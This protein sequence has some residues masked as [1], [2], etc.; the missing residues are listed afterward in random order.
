ML[1]SNLLL[2]RYHKWDKDKKSC[3]GFSKSACWQHRR[4][5]EQ[6][7]KRQPHKRKCS[8]NRIWD[9]A[10]LRQG[11]P[12]DIVTSPRPEETRIYAPAHSRRYTT[13]CATLNNYAL[14]LFGVMR[15][16][17]PKTFTVTVNNR[18]TVKTK[19]TVKDGIV[20]C[21]YAWCNPLTVFRSNANS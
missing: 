5:E 15:M 14:S 9:R 20:F 21:F 1:L 8:C 4:P 2:C 10:H 11:S 17:V 7:P 18:K 6:T 16:G 19:A 3:P 13:Q 12:G